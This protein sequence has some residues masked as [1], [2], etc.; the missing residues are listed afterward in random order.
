MKE[1]G[2]KGFPLSLRLKGRLSLFLTILLLCS[3]LLSS[4][5]P[6][7]KKQEGPVHSVLDCE[8]RS[9]DLPDTINSVSCLY[10][11]IGHACVILGQEDKLTSIV[12]GLKRDHLMKRKISDI[13][14]L[15]VPYNDQAI[16][17]EELLG[18]DPDVILL[19]S[20]TMSGGGEAD[21]LNK[22]GIPCVVIDYETMEEQKHSIEV[23]GQVFQCEE[24]AKAYVDYYDH[25]LG[26]I[27]EHVETI[28]KN[29][30][31]RVF[32][33]VNE[34][35]R[36]DLPGSFSDSILTQ[37][38]LINVVAEDGELQ[39]AEQK[40]FTTVEQIYAWDPDWILC[41][42]PSASEYYKE[43]AKMAGLSAVREGHV[44]Q[45]PVGISRWGHPGSIETPL[46]VLFLG[47]TLYPSYFEDI[48]LDQEVKYF[49]ETFVGIELSNEELKQIYSGQGM[50]DAKE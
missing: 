11:Y 15:P 26:T 3:V 23:L 45:L 41:N 13:D 12:A 35:V 30:K 10:A 14:K 48:D 24:R 49:Y 16:N 9:V 20:G 46:A 38:G 5:Q 22:T 21:K 42:E 32:H 36:T 2:K 6:Q 28:P 50:R 47:K 34:V 18:T 40:A 4:C 25:M 1:T 29:E 17:L 43:D 31:I 33:S 39:V 44:L 27:K 19:R 37:A 7:T 8:N